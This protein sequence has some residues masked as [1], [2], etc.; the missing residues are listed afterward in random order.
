MGFTDD[1]KIAVS[2]T[3]MLMQ[4]GNSMVVDV[5]MKLIDGILNEL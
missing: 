1:F 5:M 3:Q 4:A 2:D